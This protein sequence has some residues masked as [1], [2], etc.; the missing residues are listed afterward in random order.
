MSK[1]IG[2]M[3]TALLN[4]QQIRPTE[5]RKWKDAERRFERR[6]Q[7]R[8]LIEELT[9]SIGRRGVK[10]PIILGICDRSHD[11]YVADGHHRSI[12]VR[13]LGLSEF[14]FYWYWIKAWGVHMER[15]PFPYHVL[16]L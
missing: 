10:E 6:D 5:Y 11:V 9:E 13:Q 4:D 14:P 3:P 16:G 2:Q 15:E 12:V 8:K 7:D 1:Y